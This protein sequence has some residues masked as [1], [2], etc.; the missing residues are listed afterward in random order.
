MIDFAEHVRT[1]YRV[2]I[3]TGS[4]GKPG[5]TDRREVVVDDRHILRQDCNESSL[6]QQA[7]F[8]IRKEKRAIA[9]NGPTEAAPILLLIHWQLRTGKGV[10]RIEVIV[11]DE[12]V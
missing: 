1:M 11:A 8:E 6:I 3:D 4:D 12:I 7:L 2:G 10:R 9:R 5:V